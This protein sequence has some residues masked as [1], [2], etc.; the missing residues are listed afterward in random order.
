MIEEITNLEKVSKRL[1]K[2]KYREA[3]VHSY[4]KVEEILEL[5]Y[6]KEFPNSKIEWENPVTYSDKIL[7][8]Q[9]YNANITKSKLSDKL[10]AKEYVKNII[11]KDIVIPTYSVAENFDNL[12]FKNIPNDFVIK[13]NHD[14][15][16]M[17]KIIDGMTL[18]DKEYLKKKFDTILE[19]NP[20]FL[21][22][23]MQ[24]SSIS[25]K[26]FIEKSIPNFKDFVQYD[27]YMFDGK[28]YSVSDRFFDENN[29]C[30]HCWRY[31]NFEPIGIKLVSPDCKTDKVDEIIRRKP[32]NYEKMVEIAEIL[33]KDFDHVRIDLYSDGDTIYFSEFTF[34]FNNGFFDYTN[35]FNYEI[36]KQWN[37]KSNRSKLYNKPFSKNPRNGGIN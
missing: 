17:T 28:I 23:E 36:G 20:S 14:S 32:K 6:N 16:S 34:T 29:V 26:V 31:K 21:F 2:T 22:F 5:M 11:G 35:N 30:Q 18:E 7:V 12:D 15:G 27:F 3:T 8:S 1:I 25:P 19:I 4:S 37:F 33:G 10:Y 13:A 9:V 24:Y